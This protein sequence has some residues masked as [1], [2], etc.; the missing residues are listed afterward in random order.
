MEEGS[1]FES[2]VEFV[3]YPLLRWG[4]C[5]GLCTVFIKFVNV[6]C[7]CKRGWRDKR[8]IVIDLE[9]CQMKQELKRA[10]KNHG[11]SL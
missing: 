5:S 10:G 8:K 4:G 2:T 1:A 9:L 11:L 3:V 7:K 6:P